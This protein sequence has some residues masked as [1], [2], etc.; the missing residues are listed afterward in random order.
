M[1][2]VTVEKQKLISHEKW[3]E[4]TT[5]RRKTPLHCS[6]SWKHFEAVLQGG[7]WESY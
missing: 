2:E 7:F 1:T 4:K 3:K 5:D 6:F